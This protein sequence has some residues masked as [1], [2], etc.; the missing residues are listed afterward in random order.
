VTW[1]L[2]KW[3]L[4]LAGASALAALTMLMLSFGVIIF[5][6]ESYLRQNLDPVLWEKYRSDLP[7]TAE[8]IAAI[9]TLLTPYDGLG[10]LLAAFVPSFIVA[11]GVGWA[12]SAPLVR[13][14]VGLRRTAQQVRAGDLS[15]RVPEVS[16]T[17]SEIRSFARDFDALIARAERAER[18]SRASAATLAHELRTPLTVI[19]GRLQGMMDGV[20]PT[21][22]AELATLMGQV[23]VLHRLI[24]DLRFLTLFDAGRMS[25]RTEGLQLHDLIAEVLAVE[26]PVDVALVPVALRGDRAR[27][28]QAVTALMDNARRH[29]GGADRVTL[30]CEG[31]DA[32]LEVADRGPGLTEAE[33]LQVF[34][35]FYRKDKSQSEGSG[36]GLSVVRAIAAGHKGRVRA[37]P[38][39]G[40]GTV[41][42]LRL[43][44]VPGVGPGADEGAVSTDPP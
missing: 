20:F 39:P 37:L 5:L 7:L 42:E 41:F 34:D 31:P 38:R 11:V 4:A 13:H 16:P 24:D 8:D 2:R 21:A 22:P 44:L 35:R 27:L 33:A 9:E 30:R 29:A 36:L 12:G 14:L 15:A 6:Q 32:V 28:K 26:L 19:R 1:G 17:A 43:P 3:L 10:V 40:G 25:F 23:E 18:E